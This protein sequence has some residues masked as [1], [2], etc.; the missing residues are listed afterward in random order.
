[1]PL[2]FVQVPRRAASTIV[3][4]F[5]EQFTVENPMQLPVTIYDYYDPGQPLIMWTSCDI[6]EISISIFHK[7]MYILTIGQTVTKYYLPETS[8]PLTPGTATPPID[9]PE[10]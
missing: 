8:R 1:M 2:V 10:K 4:T 5:I 7:N 9:L 3:V 6:Q